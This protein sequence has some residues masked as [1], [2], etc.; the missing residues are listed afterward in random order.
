MIDDLGLKGHRIGGA[1]VS[2]IHANFILN[3]GTATTEDVEKLLEEI[4]QKVKEHYNVE[5]EQEVSVI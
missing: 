3:D 1:F 2:D 4:K 5:L